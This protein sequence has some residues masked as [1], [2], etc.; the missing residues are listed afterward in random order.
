MINRSSPKRTAKR[1]PRVRLI[2]PSLTG[3][4]AVRLPLGE[5]IAALEPLCLPPFLLVL[6]L[7]IVLVIDSI[8]SL[9][10][11]DYEHD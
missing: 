11:I 8:N 5:R 7:L 9:H 6:L 3:G 2:E 10:E 1:H 4:F